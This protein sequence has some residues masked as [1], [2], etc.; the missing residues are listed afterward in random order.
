MDCLC[1]FCCSLCSLSLPL[2]VA[3]PAHAGHDWAPIEKHYSLDSNCIRE[4]DPIGVVIFGDGITAQNQQE[5]V[6]YHTNWF[7]GNAADSQFTLNNGSSCDAMDADNQSACGSCDRYHV[8]LNYV[9][10]PNYFSFAAGHVVSTSQNVVVGTPHYE[11]WDDGCK[12]GLLGLGSTGGHRTLDYAGARDVL[13]TAMASE[14]PWEQVWYGN[15]NPQLQCESRSP[16]VARGDGFV[17]YIFSFPLA[18]P[19]DP[20]GTQC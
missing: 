12:P 16:S 1:S 7:P 18:R 8:R 14:H 3:Q 5:M 13:T 11:V 20:C 2:L 19:P 15:D 9:G 17:N 6:Q 10:H 4:T